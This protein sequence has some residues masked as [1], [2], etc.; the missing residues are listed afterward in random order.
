MKTAKATRAAS[1]L[2]SAGDAAAQGKTERSSTDHH[3]LC[4]QVLSFLNSPTTPRSSLAPGLAE[5]KNKETLGGP[6]GVNGQS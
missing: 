6:E 5:D 3:D 4:S 1:L 2:K